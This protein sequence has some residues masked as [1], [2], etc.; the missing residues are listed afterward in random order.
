MKLSTSHSGVC[1]AIFATSCSVAMLTIYSPLSES[2]KVILHLLSSLLM[3]GR[4]Q[5]MLRERRM[6]LER[7][8][9]CKR[10]SCLLLVSCLL[11]PPSLVT[12]PPPSVDHDQVA[13]AVELAQS[14]HH[15]P[16]LVRHCENQHDYSDLVSYFNKFA[17]Y[18]FSEYLFKHYLDT[19]IIATIK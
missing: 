2:S 15:F 3:L 16:T 9:M 12:P 17:S 6:L 18:G 10:S 14:Y 13:V 11:P 1:I 7:S 19:G 5:T 8:T 4:Y